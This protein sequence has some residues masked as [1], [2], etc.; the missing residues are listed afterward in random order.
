MKNIFSMTKQQLED[1]FIS[2]N[3][4]KFRATQIYEFL[5]KKRIYDI[6]KMNNIGKNIK[7]KLKEDFDFS[8]IK[9]KM[10][11]EDIAVKKYL[12]ELSDGNLI[13]SVL[14]YHDYGIK[15]ATFSGRY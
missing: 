2:I 15:K 10:K 3:D 8:F 11:Q 6:N 13:E 14:M 7:E 1:Y 12:F 9:L 4:K 5:Y